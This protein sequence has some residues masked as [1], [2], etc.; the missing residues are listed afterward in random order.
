MIK[1]IL[2]HLNFL[3]RGPIF[4]S[5]LTTFSSKQKK[6][7]KSASHE[8]VKL[9]IRQ[10]SSPS[11]TL[12]HVNNSSNSSRD[13]SDEEDLDSDREKKLLKKIDWRI[14][15]WIFCLYFL[16]VEDR[17]NVGYAMTMNKEAKHS[18]MDTAGLTPQQNNIGLGLFY[19]A[20][21]VSNGKKIS[22]TK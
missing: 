17:S 4:F 2:W 7:K 12:T 22:G 5:R 8:S 20:Y 11:V 21:I 18:L 6:M 14:V 3:E 1:Q 16:S 15:P 19:V 9:D 13:S 10:R